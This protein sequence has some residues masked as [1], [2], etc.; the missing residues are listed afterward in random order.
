LSFFS[1][2]ENLVCDELKKLEIEKLTPLEAL[3]KLEELK[4][5]LNSS[6]E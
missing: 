3:N 2:R 5:K 1:P 6:R 4:K